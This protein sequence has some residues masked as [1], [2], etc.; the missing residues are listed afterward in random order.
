MGI[1]PAAAIIR[2]LLVALTGVVVSQ[3]IIPLLLP[4]L[5]GTGQGWLITIGASVA[6]WFLSGRW[7]GR[8]R[9]EGELRQKYR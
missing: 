5:N 1:P 9:R 7:L 8:V 6:M 2:F 4:A 3:T